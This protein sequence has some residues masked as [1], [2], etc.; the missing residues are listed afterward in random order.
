MS[1]K[2]FDFFQDHSRN[3]LEVALGTERQASMQDPDGYGKRTGVCGDTVEIFLKLHKKNVRAVSYHVAG[4]INTIAC[5][6][7][8]A[9]MAE[10][11]DIDTAW[12][13]TPERVMDYLET[14]PPD[15]RHCAELAI[16]ALYSALANCLELYRHPWKKR[17]RKN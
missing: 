7:A 3:F 4:C 16:G 6:N 14:L 5:C 2:T 8:V 17:Y 12:G 15:H 9:Q 10:G 13:I 1:D 11:T